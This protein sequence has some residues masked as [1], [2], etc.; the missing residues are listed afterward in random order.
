MKNLFKVELAL[1][2]LILMII[3]GAKIY[4]YID[5]RNQDPTSD[6][7]RDAMTHFCHKISKVFEVVFWMLTNVLVLFIGVRISRAILNAN[8]GL[9]MLERDSFYRKGTAQS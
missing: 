8:L 2:I 5:V 9:M 3:M 4:D 1:V 6:P 7:F